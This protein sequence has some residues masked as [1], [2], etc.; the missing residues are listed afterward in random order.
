M[1]Y[2]PGSSAVL[3]WPTRPHPSL[4]HPFLPRA[5]TF[6][7]IG[8]FEGV[9]MNEWSRVHKANAKVMFTK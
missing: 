2:L 4:S 3:S 6:V 5:V 9:V 8:A 7:A 1:T